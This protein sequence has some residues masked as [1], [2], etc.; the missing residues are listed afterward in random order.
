MA[1]ERP[2]DRPNEETIASL[3]EA[4]DEVRDELTGIRRV[5]DEIHGDLEWAAKNHRPDDW[6]P[7][8]P[9]TSL[10]LDP[11]A[12]DWAQRVNRFAAPDIAPALQPTEPVSGTNVVA[13][14][15]V[16]SDD[17]AEQLVFCC[18]TPN[19]IWTGDPEYPGVG[20]ANCGYMVAECGSVV[21]SPAPD[22]H[23]CEL[24]PKP[25]GPAQHELF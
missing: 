21:M 6:R 14:H 24:P 15:A 3:T 7:I 13:D 5:V 12:A 20:C 8:Q 4:V 10:P 18:D 23:G 19:L 2:N 9:I 22:V 1:H 25:A 16:A 11:L 17:D